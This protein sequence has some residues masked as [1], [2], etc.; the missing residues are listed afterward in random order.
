MRV[1]DVIV[2]FV[3]DMGV[4][5]IFTVTGGG[6]MFMDDGLACNK[7][8]H[9]V[10]CHHEQAAAMA[11]VAYAKYKGIGCALVTTGC[12]ATNTITGVLNAWQDNTPCLFIAGQCKLNE[13]ISS[14]DVPIRQFGVQE[15]ASIPIV[16]SI[17]KYAE[18]IRN[19]E[20]V[21][22]HLEKA[23]YLAKEGRPGPVWIEVPMGIQQAEVDG[24]TLRHFTP[25]EFEEKRKTEITKEEME[26]VISKLQSAKRP[27][28][29]AGQGIRLSGSIEK[30][31]KFI[32]K[33]QIPVVAAR[34]GLDVLPTAHK[35]YIGRIGNKG[36]RA[37]N[38]AVQNADF[39]LSLGCRLSISTTG[40]AYDLF[41]REAEI[42]VVDID[43]NEHKKN[44]VKI[45]REI[46]ADVADVLDKLPDIQNDN[47]DIW[48]EKC[49]EWKEKYPVCTKEHYSSSEGISLYAFMNELSAYLKEDS[50]VVTDAGSAVYVPAQGIITTTKHQR[51]ITS[52]GQAEM[53]F[54]LPGT[55]GVSV[56]RDGGETIGITGDGSFQM[57]IQELQTMVYNRLPIKIF[58]WNNDGYLSIRET[59]TR[60]F[61]RRYLGTDA[62][63][64]VSFPSLKKIA[65]AYGIQYVK[66]ENIEH[67][68][69]AIEEI[70]GH[71]GPALCEVMCIRDEAVLTA[72]TAKKMPDGSVVSMPIE[73][74]KPFLDRKEFYENMIIKPISGEKD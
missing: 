48:S 31:Q 67:L 8:V 71:D 2:K 44:T 30:F 26:D 58:V 53:G 65:D 20:D 40:Y 18:M 55:V 43:P 13:I 32:D 56:A 61:E 62:S 23:V 14:V 15:A 34:M 51:Y 12:G 33:N 24:L 1:C 37:G 17:T 29:I 27:I 74:M 9:A 4:K 10:F 59:Q 39:I 11:A 36:T 25:D 28:I 7:D 66:V 6:V 3:C 63:C 41:A 5:D 50:V 46:N 64:G 42:Y 57:N 73:D 54:T 60:V 49:L 69:D 35:R 22:Y 19:P 68:G 16:Q 45:T 47:L 38:F 21:L 70:L 52:G 72:V